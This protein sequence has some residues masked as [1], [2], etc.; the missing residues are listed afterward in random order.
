M[1]V[2]ATLSPGGGGLKQGVLRKAD[3]LRK[4]LT[5]QVGGMAGRPACL[6]RVNRGQEGAGLRA[7]DNGR[8]WD[9]SHQMVQS[10]GGMSSDVGIKRFL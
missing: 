9:G 7:V 1:K 3:P 5:G 8:L 6:R 2:G 10:R 4:E